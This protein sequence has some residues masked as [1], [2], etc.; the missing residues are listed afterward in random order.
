MAETSLVVRDDND[1]PLLEPANLCDAT[2]E[3]EFPESDALWNYRFE[4]LHFDTELERMH[5]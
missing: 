1:R 3:N 5:N 4:M 2:I